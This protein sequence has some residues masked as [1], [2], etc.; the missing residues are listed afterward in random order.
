MGGLS[1]WH[2]LFLLIVVL[3]IASVVAG[4][5]WLVSKPGPSSRVWTP[6]QRDRQ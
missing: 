4:V 6:E 2:L 3:V 1:V 5:V